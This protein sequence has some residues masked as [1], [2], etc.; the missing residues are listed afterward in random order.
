MKKAL[1]YIFMFIVTLAA[2]Y[3][4]NGTLYI[5][6]NDNWQDE[7]KNHTVTNSGAVFSSNYTYFNTS[8]DGG[9]KSANLTATESDY[10]KV[11]D[12]ADLTFA[13]AGGQ[14]TPF[15]FSLWF[16][17]DS[18]DTTDTLFSKHEQATGDREYSVTVNSTGNVRIDMF[19]RVA[20]G[21]AQLTRIACNNALNTNQWYHLAITYNGSESSSGVIMY[22]D[23]KPLTT[24]DASGGVYDGMGNTDTP[25]AIGAR[26]TTFPTTELHF[27]GRIDEFKIFNKPL[28][29]TEVINIYNTGR[30]NYSIASNQTPPT[31]ENINILPY[32]PHYNNAVYASY[33][34]SDLNGQGLLYFCNI[35]KNGAFWF[36]YNYYYKVNDSTDYVFDANWID[37]TN[38]P[39]DNSYS[40][41]DEPNNGQDQRATVN[42]SYRLRNPAN[43]S[44]IIQVSTGPF[45]GLSHTNFTLPASCI[46][47]TINISYQSY[48]K[49]FTSGNVSVSC[50]NGTEYVNLGETPSLN[51][52]ENFVED[53]IFFYK[54][55]ASQDST[56]YTNATQLNINNYQDDINFSCRAYDGFYYSDWLSANITVDAPRLNITFTNLWNFST[57]GVFNATVNG[58]TYN[59]SDGEL[60]LPYF[61]PLSNITIMAPN[62]VARTYLNYNNTVP[63]NALLY[64]SILNVTV[65][66]KVTNIRLYNFS[67]NNTGDNGTGT[68]ILYPN[69]GSNTF[70]VNKTGFNDNVHT[71]IAAYA[72]NKIVRINLSNAILNISATNGATGATITSFNVNVS[73]AALGYSELFST[74]SSNINIPLKLN[75]N[76]TI[77]VSAANFTSNSS[78]R[79]ITATLYNYSVPLYQF[80]SIWLLIYDEITKEL[81]NG[82]NVTVEIISDIYSDN[83]STENGGYNVSF[84]S[85]EDYELRYKADGYALRSYY[86]T[87]ENDSVNFINLYLLNNSIS[88]Q[89]LMSVEDK[90][91]TYLEGAIVKALRYYADTNSWITVEMQKSNFFGL[92]GMNLQTNIAYYKF[93]IEYQGVTRQ[94]TTG[95][96]LYND[97]QIYF[98]VNIQDSVIYSQQNLP[99]VYRSLTFNN[100]TKTFV[101]TWSD[102]TG[103][104]RLGCLK[105]VRR[106]YS[107]DITLFD[108]C[109]A[110]TAG[111]KS[112]T[113]VN[114]LNDTFYIATG[115]IDTTTSSSEYVT[116]IIEY[117]QA[118]NF[119]ADRN[120]GLFFSFIIIAAIT[121]IGLW[122]PAVGIVLNVFAILLAFFFG[123]YIVSFEAIVGIVIIGGFI[124]LKIRQ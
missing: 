2:V 108:Q 73:N 81:F 85:P 88:S 70:T 30:A 101:Y 105:V 46:M 57:E 80:N 27:D 25:F 38:H 69:V 22:L 72:D 17:A 42:A 58:T 6:F 119:L 84:L 14:D 20:A 54:A 76:Y 114:P 62:Y 100:A 33:K 40:T 19:E 104:V 96:L 97:D 78:I 9:P 75:L 109:T 53:N 10:I 86:F 18:F 39:F 3:G 95:S 87:L 5:D 102:S 113:I 59:T 8:G 28:N 45:G 123:F 66:E 4:Q 60:E 37:N 124:I 23:S 16:S 103:L 77:I 56:V 43:D 13:N 110:S 15:T 82:T 21:G 36:D 51:D 32:N 1:L 79:N 61:E 41:E 67:A 12:A 107:N 7:W 91:G 68:I 94:E 116:D 122:K 90:G 31:M 117:F 29:N 106:M 99:N 118:Q 49:I 35:Y 111:T 74:T 112:Y 64:Q 34:A 71:F 89:I 11:N 47:S 50:F 26:Y 52:G 24:C 48:R 65:Y 115:Y 63:L 55:N 98:S 121:L 93:I 44:V 92:A 120:L 83:I